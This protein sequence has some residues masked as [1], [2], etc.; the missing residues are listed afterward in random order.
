MRDVNTDRPLSHT[1]GNMNHSMDRWNCEVRDKYHHSVNISATLRENL[2]KIVTIVAE[3]SAFSRLYLVLRE[4]LCESQ[5]EVD[6][7][8]PIVQ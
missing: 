6:Y 8:Y 3:I 5:S 7:L 1:L 2:R 4:R